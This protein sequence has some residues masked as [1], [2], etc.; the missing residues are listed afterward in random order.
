MKKNPDGLF[1]KTLLFLTVFSFWLG[2]V[3]RLSFFG[4]QVNIYFY[5]FLMGLS[6]ISLILLHGFTPFKTSYKNF[7]GIYWFF[8]YIF[9]SFFFGIAGYSLFQ[10]LVAGL[11]LFRLG[12]YLTFFI[13]LRFHLKNSDGTIKYL[14]KAVLLTFLVTILACF[15]QYFFYPDLR[16]LFYLGWDPHLFRVFG[17]FFDS[18]IAGAVLT[19]FL[20]NFIYSGNGKS[21]LWFKLAVIGLTL[22]L[23][24]LTFSRGLYLSLFVV[25]V[26][27]LFKTKKLKLFLLFIFFFLIILFLAPKPFGESVNLARLNSITSRLI[28]DKEAVSLW[29][30]NPIFGIGYNRIRYA[31]INLNLLPSDPGLVSHSGASFS[32]SY[33]IILVTGGLIGLTLFLWFLF[34]LATLSS[35]NWVYIIFLGSFSLTDNVLL[36]PFIFFLLLFILSLK[37]PS[38]PSGK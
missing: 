1:L 27:L 28:D 6:L 20:I 3:G 11:Y 35:N 21:S 34:N 30:K 14:K 5:E 9:I 15:V 8:G 12:F 19:I 25:G 33:L 23:I 24:V 29:Q 22:I 7:K 31:K 38:R 4:Q 36:H 17:T 2:M 26:A 32:S 18:S 16:N 10:N 13:Y 37:G